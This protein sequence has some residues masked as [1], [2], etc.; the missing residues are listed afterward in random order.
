MQV[1]DSQSARFKKLESCKPARG[2]QACSSAEAKE[3]I[4]PTFE[5]IEG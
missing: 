5:A 1:Y 4:K 2:K 3:L